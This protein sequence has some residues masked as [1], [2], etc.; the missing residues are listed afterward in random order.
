LYVHQKS[1]GETSCPKVNEAR[2]HSLLTGGD[3]GRRRPY[4]VSYYCNCNL[5][6]KSRSLCHAD[7]E[8][9]CRGC[10]VLPYKMFY[11]MYKIQT[12][13]VLGCSRPCCCSTMSRL[14]QSWGI[15]LGNESI[16]I[17]LLYSWNILIHVIL[18]SV[19]IN[20]DLTLPS[21]MVIGF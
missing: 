10:R 9:V 18:P 13:A 2:C 8:I 6:T 4:V 14:F 20:M 21:L 12:H 3:G 5:G 16:W 15:L 7:R 1:C 17:W 11:M 19:F